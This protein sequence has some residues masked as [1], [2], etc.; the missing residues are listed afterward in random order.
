MHFFPQTFAA[1]VAAC[2]LSA[3]HG[4]PHHIFFMVFLPSVSHL[5]AGYEVADRGCFCFWGRLWNEEMSDK[6]FKDVLI[7]PWKKSGRI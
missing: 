3:K 2:S 7:L 1:T 4:R 5:D 6:C